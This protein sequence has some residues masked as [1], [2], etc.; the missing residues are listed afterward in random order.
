MPAFDIVSEV[1]QHELSNAVDQA[2]RELSN[3]FDFKG[4][5]ARIEHNEQDITL[6]GEAEFQ[7]RQILDI[8]H[9]KF[10]KRGLDIDSLEEG[11]VASNVAE[12]RLVLSVREGID[13]DLGRKI[14]KMVKGSKIKVQIQMQQNQL[15]VTG[16]S[17][18]DLQA[19]IT[20][21]KDAKLGFPLQYKNF[22][23]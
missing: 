14:I 1:D 21:V 15:R 18:N 3:R 17:R 7:C 8:L 22:R 2:V 16:K 5:N 12:T 6:I 9:S 4:T 11:E 20:L 13:A 19:V 23:D 10:A